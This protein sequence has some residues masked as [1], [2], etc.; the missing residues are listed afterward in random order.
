MNWTATSGLVSP[1]QLIDVT[2][3]ENL[4]PDTGTDDSQELGAVLILPELVPLLE[5]VE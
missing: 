5:P 4:V 3:G 2:A 1:L